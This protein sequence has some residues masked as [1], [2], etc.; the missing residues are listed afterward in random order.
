MRGPN[1]SD[2][3]EV[4]SAAA[5]IPTVRPSLMAID[6]GPGLLPTP[7]V[8]SWTMN[9][10]D[11]AWVHLAGE[12]DMA[13]APALKEA[14]RAAQ[15]QAQVVVL[16]LRDLTFMDSSGIHAILPGSLFAKRPGHRLILVRGPKQIDR[17][18][19]LAGVTDKLDIADSALEPP[20][21]LG[22]RPTP[23]VA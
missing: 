7:F 14:L 3:A 11:A 15:T 9:D 1:S 8:C 16:D 21:R 17:L 22:S 4:V 12:L 23:W 2:R 18:L 13:A 10:L 5:D 6:D 20:A 19:E